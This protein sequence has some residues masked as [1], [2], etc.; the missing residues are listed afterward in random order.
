MKIKNI[1]NNIKD[2]NS[3]ITKQVKS[4]LPLQIQYLF[5]VYFLGLFFMM[6]FR[7]A[8]F[9]IH[10]FNTFSDVNFLLFIRSLLI[11]MRFDT[12]VSCVVLLPFAILFIIG[13]VFQIG[14][15]WYYRPLH[16]LLIFVYVL[17]LM[18]YG[19]DV[20]YFS[21]FQAHINIISLSWIQ[22]ASYVYTIIVRHP[23]LLI[24][25]AVFLIGVAW[26]LWLMY[27]LYNATLFKTI[28]PFVSKQPLAKRII[29]SVAVA[30]LCLIGI[31]S[32]FTKNQK[33]D[34]SD[35]YFSDNE[36]FNQLSISGIY[37]LHQ[38]LKDENIKDKNSL[39]RVLDF[40]EVRQIVKQQF[41]LQNDQAPVQI[42]LDNP[43]IIIFMMD[44]VAL[45]DVNKKNM[46]TLAKIKDQSLSFENLY[47]DGLHTYNGVF[48]T[49]FSYPSIFS[50]N[51]MDGVISF[52][53]NSL[54]KVL[55][56]K[57][58]Y[59]LLFSNQ[60]ENNE[61]MTSFLYRNNFNNIINS[62][63]LDGQ[64]II[65]KINAYT[66]RF[67]AF[68]VQERDSN[69]SDNQYLKMLD[70]NIL[71]FSSKIKKQQWNDN[72]VLIFVGATSQDKVPCIV[73]FPKKIKTQKNYFLAKQ[74]DIFPTIIRM[75]DKD[76]DFYDILGLNIFLNIREFAF[77]STQDKV[78][79][80]DTLWKYVWQSDGKDFLYQ[81]Q[82]DS[83]VYQPS[84]NPLV[85]EKMKKYAFAMLQKTQY[86][87]SKAKM[88][89]N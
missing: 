78:I 14:K 26:F 45:E 46:P 19:C 27:C 71:S 30:F 72:T 2:I 80:Q 25:I 40:T 13:A 70:K 50:A 85:S 33:L 69:I 31:H 75:I 53:I 34:I 89:R 28:P 64:E 18:V 63:N 55:Q 67:F 77:C 48:S 12:V 21:Y 61:Y 3:N 43:N 39:L 17:M 49:L 74:E 59:T 15:R 35:A 5:G 38:S 1:N 60:T 68:I 66:N 29:S 84:D 58:Y 81:K 86:D 65:S 54:Q 76:Y 79:V 22:S 44:D 47:A 16:I 52:R 83:L 10:C 8:L 87:I 11:G 4:L 6:V 88:K 32:G 56:N 36:F 41:I 20:A 51:S 62:Q 24:Y 82:G 7:V 57:G 42:D 73:Y 23:I 37:N 9:G